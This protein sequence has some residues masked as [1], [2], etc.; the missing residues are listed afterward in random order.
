MVNAESQVNIVEE[1]KVWELSYTKGLPK[2]ELTTQSDA[3]WGLAAISHRHADA[4]DYIYDANAGQGTFAYVV[5]TGVLLSHSE[6][7]GRAS[8]G[9]TAFPGETGDEAGHGTHTSGIIAGKTFGVAKK[10]SIIGVKVFQG[11]FSATSNIVSGFTWAANDIVAKNRTAKSAINLSLDA[12]Y[13]ASLNQAVDAASGCGV[14]SIVASG[15]QFSNASD[16][17]PASAATAITVGAIDADWAVA[18][19]S[20]WGEAVDIFAPG[21]DITSAWSGNDDDVETLSGTSM[22]TPHV[23]GLALSAM[24]VAGVSGVDAV[25]KH[26]ISTATANKIAGELNASPNLIG[27]NGNAQQEKE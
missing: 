18:D 14:L 4:T 6:F 15:N 9:F 13:T 5:D 17:S 2:R 20:N 3:P 16:F 25:T 24:S 26:L 19:Y 12:P 27:N 21:S 11:R 1:D 8:L 7:E 22:A 23:V 10:A